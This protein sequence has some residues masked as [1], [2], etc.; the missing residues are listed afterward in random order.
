MGMDVVD[1][2]KVIDPSLSEMSGDTRLV[3]INNV[4]AHQGYTWRPI[5][6]MVRYMDF[7]IHVY[8]IR[9]FISAPDAESSLVDKGKSPRRVPVQLLISDDVIDLGTVVGLMRKGTVVAVLLLSW[10]SDLLYIFSRTRFKLSSDGYETRIPAAIQGFL[11]GK[12]WL[13]EDEEAGV[14][15]FSVSLSSF[16]S[17]GQ[18]Y[19]DLGFADA[20]IKGDFTFVDK[21]KISCQ[22]FHVTYSQNGVEYYYLKQKKGMVDT[23][24]FHIHVCCF[25]VVCCVITLAL[26][27]VK[28]HRGLVLQGTRIEKEK[29]LKKLKI[30]IISSLMGLD[31]KPGNH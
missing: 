14:L 21:K 8:H 17:S 9:Q 1:I 27:R 22:P 18:N 20:Y 3:Q 31:P 12:P 4:H 23:V 16:S 5:F 30:A 13:V 7:S 15:F 29:A 19:S 11:F 6:S 10:G 28:V 24:A 26:S 25:H 2:N